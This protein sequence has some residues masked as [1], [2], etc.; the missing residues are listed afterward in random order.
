MIL[1]DVNV[2]VGAFR[3]DSP[4]HPRC[5]PWF[6]Q[7]MAGSDPF[8]ISKLAL[9]AAVRIATNRKAFNPPSPIENAFGFCNDIL[10]QPHCL[11]IETG[12]Q[13][14]GIFQ[15]LCEE[16]G[17]A[18]NDVTDA[19]YAALAIEHDCTWITC[20]RGFARFRG[21]DWQELTPP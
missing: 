10:A 12:E 20:D 2:L 3:P 13:H 21:L 5:K 17:I 11:A 1:P 9:S 6:D 19:W 15:R 4:L 14:W 16:A 8:A 18:D 7:T